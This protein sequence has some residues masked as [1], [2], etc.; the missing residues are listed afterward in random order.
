MIYTVTNLSTG[1][2]RFFLLKWS[3]ARYIIKMFDK[4][5]EFSVWKNGSAVFEKFEY[6][7][8]LTIYNEEET[9]KLTDTLHFM[10][11][12]RRVKAGLAP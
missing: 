11:K 5:V 7:D 4:H 6:T 3:A 2:K 1:K 12:G 9:K 10:L 8:F